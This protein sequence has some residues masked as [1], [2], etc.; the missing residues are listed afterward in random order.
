MPEMRNLTECLRMK[1][2]VLL[3]P[4]EST[5]VVVRCVS[6]DVVFLEVKIE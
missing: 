6:L 1:Y 3:L 5:I 2:Y 4:C